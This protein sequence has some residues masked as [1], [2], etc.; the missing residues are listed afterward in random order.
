MLFMVTVVQ[1]AMTVR[2]SDWIYVFAIFF[3]NV[4][5]RLKLFFDTNEKQQ[6]ILF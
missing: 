6:K 1:N 5:I 3:V 2:Q 4:F